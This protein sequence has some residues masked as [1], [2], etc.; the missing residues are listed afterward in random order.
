MWV[1]AGVLGTA[2]LYGSGSSMPSGK[3][4][5]GAEVGA[6]RKV[7]VTSCLRIRLRCDRSGVSRPDFLTH[8]SLNV[9]YCEKNSERARGLLEESTG[10]ARLEYVNY[11][12]VN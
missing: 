3:R 4:G 6:M 2:I 10:M 7:V 5:R 8:L 9:N 1:R 11:P 12:D